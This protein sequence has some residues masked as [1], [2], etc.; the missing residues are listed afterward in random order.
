VSAPVRIGV[1]GAGALGYHHIRL[2]RELDGAVCAGFHDHDPARA[3]RVAGELGVSAF[4]SLDS[5]L[6][7]CDAL[8][9]VVPTSAHAAVAQQA[10]AQ[11]KH[12][13]VEKPLC[14]TLAEADAMLDAARS[15][16]VLIQTGHIERFNRAMRAAM[17]YVDQPRFISSERLAPFNPRGT[18]VAVV[19]DLMIHD[20]D[21]VST[22]VGGPVR[23]VHAVGVPV[24]TPNIDIANA[25][26][27][28][29]SGAVATIT[30]SRVSRERMRKVRIFQSSGYLSLDLA[31][32][33]GEFYRV[34]GDVD[35]VA[36]AAG[37]LSMESFVEVMPLDAPEGEPLRLELQS[38]VD[39][40]RGL[41]PVVVTG[42]DG[43][44]ALAVAL[45]ILDAIGAP[46]SALTGA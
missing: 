11:G 41:S 31:A 2:L 43:R 12:L 44:A 46:G 21:L 45:R 39:A 6:D 23:D 32:G 24:L 13:L 36:L 16:G 19:L 38:F 37:P 5:L 7:A 18:D 29:A 3:A 15:A 30:S 42:E 10:I 40:V 8:C 28:F 20:I 17:P 14:T 33:T 34:R 26:L 25:R 4:A 9:I 22:L 35:P 27:G 1:A